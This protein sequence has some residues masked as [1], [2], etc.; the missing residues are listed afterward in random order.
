MWPTSDL[1]AVLYLN[2]A[3]ERVLGYKAVDSQLTRFSCIFG[4]NTPP[5]CGSN[6]SQLQTEI[7]PYCNEK[8]GKV[9]CI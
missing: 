1:E 7:K 6:V 5:F 2:H 9:Y 3:S 4:R 8:Q